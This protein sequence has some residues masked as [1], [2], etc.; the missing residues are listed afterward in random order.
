M[1]GSDGSIPPSAGSVPHQ[2]SG[3]SSPCS[4]SSSGGSRHP[5]SALKKWLTNPVRKLSSDARGGTGKAE[6]QM[7]RSDGRQPPSLL[8]HSETQPRPLEPHE[9]YTILP[10]GDTVRLKDRHTGYILHLLHLKTCYALVCNGC[11]VYV[12][13]VWKDGLSSPAA[14]IPTQPPSQSLLSDL[15]QGRDTQS[16]VMSLFYSV[17]LYSSLFY[18]VLSQLF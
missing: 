5:V 11:C 16:L 14:P 18:V 9:S 8:S 13:Q 1:A 2:A 6:K 7:N 17:L 12:A 15:L 3:S 10:A 4:H